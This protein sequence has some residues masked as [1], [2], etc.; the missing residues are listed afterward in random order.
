V[1]GYSL[2]LLAHLLC[3][4]FERPGFEFTN[5][6]SILR[7]NLPR[8]LLGSPGR[9]GG[10][11][12]GRL[13]TFLDSKTVSRQPARYSLPGGCGGMNLTL[14]VELARELQTPCWIR[15]SDRAEV[16]VA[17]VG[18]RLEEV[19]MVEGVEQFESELEALGFR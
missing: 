15:G 5:W 9:G 12:P 6:N 19:R 4:D 1:Y 3:T 13:Q 14:P 18:I 17:Q 8:V 10:G 16:L 7:T 11:S 2:S